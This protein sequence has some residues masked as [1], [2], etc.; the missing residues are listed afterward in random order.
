MVCVRVSCVCIG[1][2]AWGRVHYHWQ[3]SGYDSKQTERNKSVCSNASSMRTVCCC[4][5]ARLYKLMGVR[6]CAGAC[7]GCGCV[8]LRAEHCRTTAKVARAAPPF[9]LPRTLAARSSLPA[10]L[11]VSCP[12]HIFLS[13]PFLRH[14]G[15]ERTVCIAP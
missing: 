15:C 3:P 12:L 13:A 2:W 4:D 11:H 9:A 8:P 14:R 6:V 5:R 7:C 10:S 1:R